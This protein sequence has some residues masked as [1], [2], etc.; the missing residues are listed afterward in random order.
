VTGSS[1]GKLEQIVSLNIPS[2]LKTLGS[3]NLE[4]GWVLLGYHCIPLTI[5]YVLFIMNV[6]LFQM[7]CIPCP[8]NEG[9][10]SVKIV[11]RYPQDQDE[12]K[13]MI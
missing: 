3:S 11:Q 5:S 6:G 1:I 9:G 12:P 10:K 7:T 13:V 4:D 2:R 8:R